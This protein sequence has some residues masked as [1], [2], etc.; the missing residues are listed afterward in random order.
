MLVDLE[1]D[2]ARSSLAYWQARSRRLPRYAV[3]K[4]REAREMAARWEARVAEAERAAYGRGLAGMLALVVAEGRVPQGLRRTG[5][6]VA[7]RTAQLAFVAATVMLVT[8]VAAVAVVAE[9]VSS[10]V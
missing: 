6:R 4:R 2:D 8:A 3:R 5:R 10:I 1:L 9:L 7:R